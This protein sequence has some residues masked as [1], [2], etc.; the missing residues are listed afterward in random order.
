[1]KRTLKFN[2]FLI[3]AVSTAVVVSTTMPIVPFNVLHTE[4]SN[5]DFPD[6]KSGTYYYDA[7]TDL[8][9]RGV[10]NGFSDG[11]FKP[12]QEVNRG[13]AA[14]MIASSLSLNGKIMKDPGFTDVKQGDRFYKAIAALVEAGVISGKTENSFN[15]NEPITRAELAKIISLAYKLKENKESV[16]KFS[17]VHPDAWYS[18]YVGALIDHQ[19]TD[20]YSQTSF[21]T[22]KT[23]TRGQ[24][25]TFINRAEKIL[26][27]DPIAKVQTIEKVTNDT[28]TVNG[29]EYKVAS[30]LASLFNQSNELALKNAVMKFDVNN[31]M[32]T[33]VTQLELLQY[34][35]KT[36]EMVLDAKGAVISGNMK[37]S[38]DY[39]SIKNVTIKGNLDVGK[40]VENQ[41][42]S[43]TITV[44]GNTTVHNEASTTYTKAS[45]DPF[46]S[47]TILPDKVAVDYTNRVIFEQANLGIVQLNRNGVDVVVNGSTSIKEVNASSNVRM[48]VAS[49]AK[50]STVILQPG[51]ENMEI[52]GDISQ[53]IV[54]GKNPVTI[55]GIANINQVIVQQQHEVLLKIIGQIQLLEVQNAAVKITLIEKAKVG[56]LVLPEGM[57]AKDIIANYEKI[58]AN[59]AKIGGK[60][61]PDLIPVTTP[62][63]SSP[64]GNDEGTPSAPRDQTA[65]IV[66]GVTA[67]NIAE[68]SVHIKLTS[69]ETG[70]VYYVVLPAEAVA[71]SNAQIKTGQNGIGES[72]EL[73]GNKTVSSASE[74]TIYISGL[75]TNTDY[76]VYVVAEDSAGNVSSVSSVGVTTL[77]NHG[78]T[79]VNKEALSTEIAI[80]EA[81]IQSEYTEVTW[82]P[83][84][85]AL[86]AANFIFEKVDA[87]QEEV[88]Q[89]L[90]NLTATMNALV[91]KGIDIAPVLTNVT[92]NPGTIA[93][94]KF[95]IDDLPVGASKLMFKILD[96]DANDP[97]P[98]IDDIFDGIEPAMNE[99][100]IDGISV[101]KKLYIAAVDSDN[102]IKAY[103]I[104]TLSETDIY[105]DQTAPSISGVTATNITE[106]SVDIKLTS[107]ESGE[108]YYMVLPADAQTPSNLQI[109]A[110]LNSAGEAVALKGNKA[111][112]SGLEL[113][114]QISGLTANTDY[115]AYVVAEDG[116]GNLSSV[117]S[118][119]IKTFS[120]T[121]DLEKLIIKTNNVNP[122][123]AKLG[124]KATIEI[125]A[126][127]DITISNGIISIG[128]HDGKNN[129]EI[130]DADDADNSTW[131][132]VYTFNAADT[133]GDVTFSFD[134]TDANGKNVSVGNSQLP[135]SSKVTFDKTAPAI[136]GVVEDGEYK[137]K[138][139]PEFVE[140]IGKISIGGGS[141]IPFIS[142]TEL[143][144]VNSYQLIVTDEAGNQATARFYVTAS[145][146]PYTPVTIPEKEYFDKE[147]IFAS[148]PKQLVVPLTNGENTMIPLSW[149]D[150]DKFNPQQP[151]E[152][153]FTSSF[154]QIGTDT[155]KIDINDI[156]AP[157]V[158]VKVTELQASS[159]KLYLNFDGPLADISG[160]GNEVTLVNPS[161]I[162]FVN[163][164]PSGRAISFNGV[165][166]KGAVSIIQNDSLK[167]NNEVTVSYWLSMKNY[168]GEYNDDNHFE[169]YGNHAIFAKS[170]EGGISSYIYTRSEKA[171][172]W[173]NRTP[174]QSII[175]SNPF[176]LGEWVHVAFTISETESKG[177]I[178]GSLVSSIALSTPADLS[179]S[180]SG[181]FYIGWMNESWY[182]L[183]GDIDNFRMYD[184]ALS[185]QEIEKLYIHKQ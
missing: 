109:K 133:E 67:T 30:S 98:K 171:D 119:D 172:L 91:L 113:T 65:P 1:M 108:V 41:F 120:S 135:N 49:G 35:T 33:N 17:D 14:Q 96:M 32:I 137:D 3:A 12:S 84:H 16:G 158:V 136:T 124:D 47:K 104:H 148:L 74:A 116:A 89:T 128:G 34:G 166:K 149:E 90:A 72:V 44:E 25:A 165:N 105:I 177:Y 122:A 118:V 68:T 125:K 170:G 60:S 129:L 162:N 48:S 43:Q 58:K 21:G 173:Y 181:P 46:Y 107:N 69:N 53:L 151:G 160:S 18:G 134:M 112:M 79:P 9:N 182:A 153:K 23:V 27:E 102:K 183:H 180:N 26:H 66:S 127:R 70:E 154:G 29:V 164:G 24:I 50:I 57:K 159:L 56:N 92:V 8:A 178:N 146:M 28:V 62:E 141:Y 163:D 150:S 39:V 184:K 157:V 139:I 85:A 161:N 110:G 117:A 143:K 82:I 142:G 101:G 42:H 130:T 38:G 73:K 10:M 167:L 78:Q 87:T 174:N 6:V 115:N 145:L 144:Q 13:Q 185:I 114:I 111:V 36:N 15:P 61:N 83:F 40:E 179:V 20:G 152:Y 55:N 54:A 121:L 88:D 76:K 51:A 175:V 155:I 2:K 123:L 37:I 100:I 59:F 75:T 138:V 19:I 131:N 45:G 168:Y 86:T 106:A 4:A 64:I 147:E 63:P 7:V 31:G 11:T 97:T 95:M 81:K 99:D 93:G 103:K 126:E 22:P 169:F 132:I 140:G 52:N 176:R 71:P 94:I 5:K 156:V 80:A 77:S